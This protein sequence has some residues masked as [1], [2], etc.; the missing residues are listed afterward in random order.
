M[1]KKKKKRYY[2]LCQPNGSS[3]L[4]VYLILNSIIYIHFKQ[5]YLHTLYEQDVVEFPIF[6]RLYKQ[7]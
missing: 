5:H 7:L 2:K 1:Q 3:L 4:P 6:S